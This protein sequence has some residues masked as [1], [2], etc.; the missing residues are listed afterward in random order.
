[1]LQII[2]AVEGPMALLDCVP[3]PRGCSWSAE[4]PAAAVWLSVQEGVEDTLRGMSL[5]ELVSTPRRN[6]RVESTPESIKSPA[7]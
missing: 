7:T 3:D 1:M 2:E 6:G 5:E 4:C